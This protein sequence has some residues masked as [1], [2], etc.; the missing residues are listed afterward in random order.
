MGQPFLYFILLLFHFLTNRSFIIAHWR[1]QWFRL[2]ILTLQVSCITLSTERKL[3]INST[4]NFSIPSWVLTPSLLQWWESFEITFTL[5]HAELPW[6]SSFLKLDTEQS[7]L[8]RLSLSQFSKAKLSRKAFCTHVFPVS[9]LRQELTFLP[10][11]SSGLWL[12]TRTPTSI[13]LQIHR[14]RQ[15]RQL[16][17][18]QRRALLKIK[19]IVWA[20]YI[21][22]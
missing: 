6:T 19:T 14:L 8:F 22:V 18:L 4:V 10:L 16:P 5:W 7:R 17:A 20:T 13:H 21:R 15:Q 11:P 12:F 2:K 3:K 9:F 1:I